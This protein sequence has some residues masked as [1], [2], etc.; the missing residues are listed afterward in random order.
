M[1]KVG[2]PTGLV[3]RQA[4][5]AWHF[6]RR[7]PTDVAER[8]GQAEFVVSL[9]TGLYAEALKRRPAA[10]AYYL[11][12]IA[13]ARNESAGGPFRPHTQARDGLNAGNILALR[14]ARSLA[15]LEK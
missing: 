13:D 14:S 5:R 12:K 7:F 1:P 8:L 15:T 4:S 2:K 9:H 10:E 11:Q 6:R 3:K